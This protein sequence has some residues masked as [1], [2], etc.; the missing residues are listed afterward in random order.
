[1]LGGH[2]ARVPLDYP[3][4]SSLEPRH[5]MCNLKQ[6]NGIEVAYTSETPGMH[7]YKINVTN[8]EISAGHSTHWKS[9]NIY[10]YKGGLYDR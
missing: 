7:L 5:S 6:G 10:G 9:G 3:T 2:R 8:T 1:M 4:G